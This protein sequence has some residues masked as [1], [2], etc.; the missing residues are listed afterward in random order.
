MFSSSQ[1]KLISYFENAV[2]KDSLRQCYIIKGEEG[3]GKKTLC[4]ALARCILCENGRGCGECN[5]CKS[6]EKGANPDF[7]LIS[8][9][10]SKIIE[11]KKIRDMIKE[12]YVKPIGS[13]YRLFVIEN[14]HLMDAPAQNA[15]L[16]IIEEPPAFAVFILVCDN[17]NA[18]LPTI[19]SRA[20]LLELE[21]WSIEDLRQACPL[22][23]E[24]EY[25]YTYCLGS[26]GMLKKISEDES[27]SVLR[28]GLIKT[29]IG[30]FSSGDYSVYDAIDYWQANKEQ[31][32]SMIDILIMFLRDV[33]LYKSSMPQ[34]MANTDKL[35]EIQTVSDKVS[36][37][38]C[39]DMLK[40]ANEAPLIFGRY[41][42]FNMASQTL[43]MQLKKE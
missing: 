28:D 15:I 17:L 4:R 19:L 30:I 11:I 22:K 18:L 20:Q 12:V 5:S 6:L 36:K 33:M 39:F 25:M 29:F 41:G 31:K 23:K 40:T 9:G 1:K 43:L 34:L 26:I 7:K 16:K 13:K 21:K 32:D 38:K 2:R 3:L 35:K 24:D 27:F 42:N 10:D 14:A 37:K 8:N